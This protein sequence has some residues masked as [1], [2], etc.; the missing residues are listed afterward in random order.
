[1]GIMGDT[2]SEP[3]YL[4]SPTLPR[5]AQQESPGP[6]GWGYRYEQVIATWSDKFRTG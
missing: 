4:L 1:M 5:S 3:C 6:D 2:V